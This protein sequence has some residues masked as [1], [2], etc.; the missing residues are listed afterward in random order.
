MSPAVDRSRAARW[1]ALALVTAVVAVL[2]DRVGVPSAALFVALAVAT[3]FAL[4][5]WGPG[6]VPRTASM[7]AQAVLG[8]EIGTLLDRDTMSSLGSDWIWVVV[9]SLGTLVLSIAAGAL[10]GLHRDLDATTGALALVAGG[11]SGMVAIA[12]DLGGDE[13]VVA[14]VQY[15]RVLLVTASLPFVATVVFSADTGQSGSVV[16]AS[17]PLW[18]DALFIAVCLLVG[19]PLG[20]LI[21]L[22][23]PALLGPLL[24]SGAADLLGW[25]GNAGVPFLLLQL[26]YIVIGWQAG[27]QFTLD[28]LKSIGR[29]IPWAVLLIIA[30]AVGCALLGLILV[31]TTGITP[32]EAYLATTPGGIYAVLALAAASSVNV[33]FVVAAQVLRVFMMLLVVPL[34]TRARRRD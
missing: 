10:L 23:A 19:I 30:I 9:V 13:R 18:T 3:V 27:L 28:S 22:P 29:I 7:G 32:Y 25:T 34:F 6:K 31:G 8:V 4:C 21:R 33:T 12:R 15:V 14:V 1:T 26:V 16:T 24:I 20:R 5:G 17:A 11:A 2:A